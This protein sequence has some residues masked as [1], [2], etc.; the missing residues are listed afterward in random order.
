M[1]SLIKDKKYG[2]SKEESVSFDLKFNSLLEFSIAFLDNPYIFKKS[3]Q[4]RIN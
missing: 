3:N 4:L 2:S 1:D